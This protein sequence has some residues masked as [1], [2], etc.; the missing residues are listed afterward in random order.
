MLP[1]HCSCTTHI[2]QQFTITRL[3]HPNKIVETIM[4]QNSGNDHATLCSGKRS[5]SHVKMRICNGI[6]QIGRQVKTEKFRE[7]MNTLRIIW[8]LGQTQSPGPGACS[9]RS[10]ARPPKPDPSHTATHYPHSQTD[11]PGVPASRRRLVVPLPK[12]KPTQ[13]PSPP[14][15]P[16]QLL[17]SETLERHRRQQ[18]PEEEEEEAR[19]LDRE[20]KRGWGSSSRSGRSGTSRRA[21]CPSPCSASA[22]R[23][24]SPS[25]SARPSTSTT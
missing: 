4:P 6:I 7:N 19:R 24:S 15:R 3:N 13:K 8:A 16:P 25:A 21:A 23:P 9:R 17:R 14:A 11:L 5:I 12:P 18:Q 2:H 20:R 10:Q 1:Y 22:A